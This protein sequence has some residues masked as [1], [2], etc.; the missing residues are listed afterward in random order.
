[1]S[2]TSCSLFCIENTK[3]A[4]PSQ[5]VHAFRKHVFRCLAQR[6]TR[7]VSCGRSGVERDHTK[8]EKESG[9]SMS[10]T[11]QRDE[12]SA[13]A[14]QSPMAQPIAAHS[15]PA[16]WGDIRFCLFSICVLLTL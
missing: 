8:R 14:T 10:L 13:S 4:S 15:G 11:E 5:W 16:Q 1:M 3:Q 6:P 12:G 2:L 7:A 9:T